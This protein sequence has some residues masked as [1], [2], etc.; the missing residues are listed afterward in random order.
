MCKIQTLFFITHFKSF[1][2]QE[3]GHGVE[4][5]NLQEYLR[6]FSVTEVIYFKLMK[7]DKK[8]LLPHMIDGSS[9]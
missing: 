4:K 9:I 8:N 6:F 1:R 5:N 3:H 2:F 7:N